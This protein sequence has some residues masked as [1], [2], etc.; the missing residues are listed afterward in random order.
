MLIYVALYSLGVLLTCYPLCKQFVRIGWLENVPFA[1]GKNWFSGWH[2][3]IQRRYFPG[4][5]SRHYERTS[6]AGLLAI[7]PAVSYSCPIPC[8][9]N[10]TFGHPAPHQSDHRDFPG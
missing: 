3:Q 4:M 2:R 10:P 5:M 6:P 9:N 8:A 1:D 7:W